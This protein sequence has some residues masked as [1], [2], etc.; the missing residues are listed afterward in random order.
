VKI[1]FTILLIFIIAISLQA[2]APVKK[3]IMQLLEKS[4]AP[5]VSVKEAFSKVTTNTDY[6]GSKCSAEKLFQSVDQEVKAVEAEYKAQE[7]SITSSGMPGLSPENAKKMGDPEMKKKMK[8]MSKEEKIKMAMEMMKSAPAG[9]AEMDPPPVR[10]ALDEWQKIYNNMQTDFQKSVAE[11]QVETKLNEEYQKSQDEISKW[12]QDEINKLPQISSGEMSAPDPAKVKQ[13]KLKAADKHIALADK[14]L[15]KTRSDW[16]ASVDRTK[17]KYTPFYKKL[18]VANY[19]ADTKNFSSKKILSDAQMMI[20]QDISHQIEQ[21]RNAWEESA[22]WQ[23]RRVDI[24]KQKI[25]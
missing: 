11:Q 7:K 20:L 12:E 19:A 6:N 13:V 10:A 2:Q 1:I 16:R 18:I 17:T 24:E 8:G 23:A 25:E 5:P 9:G 22:S 14:H 4:P 3:D 15:E 21:S